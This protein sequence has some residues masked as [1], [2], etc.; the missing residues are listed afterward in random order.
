MQP[1]IDLK[2]LIDSRTERFKYKYEQDPSAHTRMVG[3]AF[4]RPNSPLS[5]EEVIPQLN[6]WHYRSGD[7]IDFYFAGYTYPH[8][9]GP[10]YIEVPMPGSKPWLYSAVRF[11]DFR[12]EI[13]SITTWRYSGSCELLLT[14]A[15]FDKKSERAYLDFSSMICC[16]LDAMK[17]DQAIQ[18]VERFFE[19]VFR[20]AETANDD[21]PTWG[22]SDAQGIGIAGSALKRVVLSLLPKSLDADYK[23]A[24]HFVVRDAGLA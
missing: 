6:D 5:R 22:F 19:S 12:R 20:F 2:D 13:E 1:A 11:N 10:G 17:N 8:P 9:P 21:D 23:R 18:S 15:R 7:H 4:A 16:Q 14:N 3:I 24:E